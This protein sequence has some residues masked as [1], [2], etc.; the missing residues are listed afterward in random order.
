MARAVIITSYL[1][2]PIDIPSILRQDDYVVCLDGGIDIAR[3]CSIVPHLLLGDFDSVCKND[4]GTSTCPIKSIA[5]AH[6]GLST[7]STASATSRSSESSTLPSSADTS[8]DPNDS[9]LPALQDLPES[10][11]ELAAW[12]RD[13]GIEIRCYPPEKDYTDLELA[14][15]ILDPTRTPDI[16]IVGG[17]GG[18]LDQT[19]VNIQM[20]QRYTMRPGDTDNCDD[21][22]GYN[23]ETGH[24]GTMSCGVAEIGDGA[25]DVGTGSSEP[26][27]RRIEIIDGHNRCFVVHGNEGGGHH[28]CSTEDPGK[29]S[30]AGRFSPA[31]SGGDPGRAGVG[32]STR[33]YK[34][35]KV[36]ESYLSLLPLTEECSGVDLQGV[37][38]PL[39]DATLH[40]GASL[41]ISNEFRAEEA[42][43]RL[44]TGSL[45]V[46]VTKGNQN[47]TI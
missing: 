20:L 35:P 24:S 41:S 10:A 31:A 37:K 12:A 46:I 33:V 2:H 43:L 38:Y 15:R 23:D 29:S 42:V 40:R 32:D 47:D 25:K 6:Q 4:P 22:T 16:L 3:R 30:G 5:S 28:T 7:T 19:L 13:N 26:R 17:L 27:Y 11:K 18:R 1:E 21:A 14:L 36:P 34:I 39:T 45:L 44:R 9:P 8:G